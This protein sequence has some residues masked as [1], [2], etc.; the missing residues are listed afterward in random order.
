SAPPEVLG[1]AA[2]SIAGDYVFAVTVKKAEVYVYDAKTGRQVKVL[3]PGPEVFGET[4]WVDIHHFYAEK[5]GHH[6]EYLVFV[7]EDA[8]AKVMMYRF[9]S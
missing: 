1:P 7:E 6:R 2:M 3:R 4:G 5:H 8:K 9:N